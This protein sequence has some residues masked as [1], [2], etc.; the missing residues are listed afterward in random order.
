MQALEFNNRVV[1]FFDR[2]IYF[3]CLGYQEEELKCQGKPKEGI[4]A[5][6]FH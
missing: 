1:L 3:T 5:K 4:M 6:M 2:A